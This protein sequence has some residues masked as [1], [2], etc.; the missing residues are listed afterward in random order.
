MA[1]ST[2]TGREWDGD[3]TQV[4][5]LIRQAAFYV[6]VSEDLRPR[7]LENARDRQV[8]RSSA[9]RAT[10]LLVAMIA[11]GSSLERL[12]SYW[13]ASSASVVDRTVCPTAVDIFSLTDSDSHSLGGADA[14][15]VAQAFVELRTRQAQLLLTATQ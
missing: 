6:D 15:S 5:Q 7:V 9:R 13:R 11:L 10:L 3:V 2:A 8:R 14:W 4:E 12:S 1:E